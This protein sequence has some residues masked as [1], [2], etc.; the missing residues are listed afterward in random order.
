[1]PN[2]YFGSL[3]G[4]PGDRILMTINTRGRVVYRTQAGVDVFPL[5][6]SRLI[7]GKRVTGGFRYSIADALGGREAWSVKAR[8]SFGGG[9]VGDSGNP[10]CQ[11]RKEAQKKVGYSACHR[12]DFLDSLRVKHPVQ[13]GE[14][15]CGCSPDCLLEKQPKYRRERIFGLLP[16]ENS[17]KQGLFPPMENNFAED[18]YPSA[19]G[20][21]PRADLWKLFSRS[22]SRRK[23]PRIQCGRNSQV[24][25]MA[26]TRAA[27]FLEWLAT[28][29]AK[30][31]NG[32]LFIA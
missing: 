15:F 29:V 6:K 3:A 30:G 21:E 24:I 27:P 8:W 11:R 25:A 7:D 20:Q 17:A 16:I 32:F 1:V 22:G 13:G 12:R 4:T 9:R 18:K 14:W 19:S 28:L 31:L 5:F 2:P 23:P 26:Q 10:N